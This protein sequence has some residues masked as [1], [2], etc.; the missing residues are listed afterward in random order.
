MSPQE[1]AVKPESF[2]TFGELLRY[3]RKRSQLSRAELA[4]AAGYSESL[5]ARLELNQRRPDPVTIQARFVPALELD[6]EPAWVER[7]L[8]LAAGS[9]TIKTEKQGAPDIG[10][11]SV[12]TPS[13]F[14]AASWLLA[15]KLFVPHPQTQDVRRHRLLAQLDRA[16]AVPLTLVVA[17]PGYGKTNLIATWIA[18]RIAAESRDEAQYDSTSNRSS[19]IVDHSMF[20]WVSLDHGDNDLATF[21][22]YLVAACRRFDPE[23]GTTT[24]AMLQQMAALPLETILAPLLN[25]LAI[26]PNR[27]VLV[28]EDAHLLHDRRVH[29]ALAFLIEHLPPRVHIIVSSREE[30]PLP[31][32]RLRAAG[33]LLEIHSRDLRFTAVESSTFLREAMRVDVTDG[34]IA[35]LDARTE[36]W[37]AGLQLAAL[38][39]RERPNPGGI[40]DTISGSSRYFVD[41]LTDEVI[42]RLP[43]HLKTFVLQTSILDRLCG[44]LC[45]AVLGVGGQEPVIRETKLIPDAYSQIM[46][47]ELE[48]RQLF[49]LALDGERYWYRYHHLFADLLR[50]RLEQGIGAERVAVLHGR[51]SRWY[52]AQELIDEAIHHALAAGAPEQAARMVEERAEMLIMTSAFATLLRWLA[53]LPQALIYSNHRLALAKSAALLTGGD[54]SE[55]E[56]LQEAAERVGPSAVPEH[57]TTGIADAGWLDDVRDMVLIHRSLIARS[58]NDPAHAITL[59]RAALEHLPERFWFLHAIAGWN[60]GMAYLLTGD[61]SAAEQAFRKVWSDNHAP[62]RIYARIVAAHSQAH[63]KGV[64]GQLRAAEEFYRTT[65]EEVASLGVPM[66]AVAMLH[67]G[68][69]DVLYQ[70][71][72]LEAATHHLSEGLRLGKQFGQL[73]VLAAGYAIRTR[74]HQARGDAAN[75]AAEPAQTEATLPTGIF[76]GWSLLRARAWLAQGNTA[77]AERWATRNRV[78]VS[79]PADYGHETEQLVLARVLLVKRA[80]AQALP[81]LER[82]HADSETAGRVGITIE[83]LVLEALALFGSGK[84]DAALQTLE[85]ALVLAEPHSYVRL[86]VDEG[87]PMAALLGLVQERGTKPE[88]ASKLLAAFPENA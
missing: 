69:A 66:P 35:V 36:G 26:L 57:A 76:D 33:K 56:R 49:L 2:T 30:L 18:E 17:P 51:A 32:A 20:A 39:L 13:R 12:L 11:S 54:F 27:N 73:D 81:L 71:N 16:L 28:L 83:V 87:E 47:E 52:E 24:S 70:W 53:L 15:T 34:D 48:R 68:L 7:L 38:A 63:I 67:V 23:V 1:Q 37:A 21:V 77:D 75:A 79:T 44:P 14:D 22:R 62:E 8:T 4:R 19:L 46:L 64:R 58:Q 74:L 59:M 25:D 41:Y 72:D 85:R 61:L 42:D 82:L 40:V 84:Q 55:V 6:T 10:N 9:E 43:A 5:V 60:L 86:F 3:L 45:D 50:A 78:G 80:F 31:V 29:S 65:L 88:Y